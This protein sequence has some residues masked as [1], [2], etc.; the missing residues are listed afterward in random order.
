MSAFQF[1]ENYIKYCTDFNTCLSSSF[2][3]E[4]EKCLEE[5]QRLGLLFRRYE[6]R[7]NMYVVYCQ[8]K[9]KSEYI[10][11]EY[12]D[13]FFEVSIIDAFNCCFFYVQFLQKVSL[14]GANLNWVF[15]SVTI[16]RFW[17]ILS[18]FLYAFPVF[19]S[20][21]S[22][23]HSHCCFLCLE[24]QPSLSKSDFQDNVNLLWVFK[25]WCPL[26]PKGDPGSWENQKLLWPVCFPAGLTSMHY[27]CFVTTPT[28]Q[29]VHKYKH[30][31]Y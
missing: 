5:P 6:R 17:A 16:A 19:L 7:L 10:V 11:S 8:N 23:F 15:R 21:F 29:V 27:W 13:T 3:A 9:P 30:Y 14:R 24:C 12:I 20:D 28:R 31:C 2:C 1:L 25:V 26:S 18:S 22:G 4:I